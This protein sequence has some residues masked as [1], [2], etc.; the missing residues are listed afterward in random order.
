M[1]S[2]SV[3]EINAVAYAKTWKDW[4]REERQETLAYEKDI[5]DIFGLDRQGVLRIRDLLGTIGGYLC[6]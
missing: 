4:S 5:M 1:L 6:F 3:I 2:W